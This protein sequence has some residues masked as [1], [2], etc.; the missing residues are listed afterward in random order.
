VGA[1]PDKSDE[2]RQYE[3]LFPYVEEVKGLSLSSEATQDPT[4]VPP[5]N[6]TLYVPKYGYIP[7]FPPFDLVLF[8]PGTND[9][10]P[11][12]I[13][14]IQVSLMEFA[15]HEISKGKGGRLQKFFGLVR[16]M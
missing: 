2:I 1:V 16:G 11:A 3:I 12:K 4:F 9:R 10:N 7:N 5:V 6:T 13:Q 8:Y 15:K 14:F